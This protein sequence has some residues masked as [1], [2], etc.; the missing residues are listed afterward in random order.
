MKIGVSSYS[1]SR[2]VSTGKLNFLDIPA[3][4]REQGFDVLE[5]STFSLPAGETPLT[6]APKVRAACD[7]AGIPVANYTIGAD[8]LRGSGGDW[9]AG[10]ASGRRSPRGEDPRRAGHAPRCDGRF[11]RRPKGPQ[12][13][14]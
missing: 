3:K 8:F 9:M 4:A 7:K 11:S 13:L 2:L 5:F 6:F 10:P 1:Y 12:G 14:R